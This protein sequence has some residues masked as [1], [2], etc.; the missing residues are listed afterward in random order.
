MNRWLVSSV[1]FFFLT[2]AG[3]C[4]PGTVDVFP[5]LE[6]RFSFESGWDGWAAGARD[7][8]EPPAPWGA[9]LTSEA[10]LDGSRSLALSLDNGSAQGRVFIRRRFDLLPDTPYR[11][12]LTFGL[13]TRDGDLNPWTL[14]GGAA[15]SATAVGAALVTIGDTGGPG[16]A[17][18]AWVP[19]T[20]AIDFQTA[21][22]DGRVWIALGI[23]GTSPFSREYLLDDLTVSIRRR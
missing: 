10:A 3:V 5:E 20:A 18:L 15:P 23:W 21:S 16:G 9:R 4:D 17:E 2:F 1:G 19:E 8:G 13:G 12:E 14:V 6:E 22:D 11:A 7:L